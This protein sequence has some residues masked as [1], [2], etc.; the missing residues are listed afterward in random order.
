MRLVLFIC[1]LISAA[2]SALAQESQPITKRGRGISEVPQVQE[3]LIVS[4][5]TSGLGDVS[6]MI[7]DVDGSIYTSDQT[8]GRVFKVIDRNKDGVLDQSRVIADGFSSPSGLAVIGNYLYVADAKAIWTVPLNGGPKTAFVSLG[9]SKS[10]GGSRPL[11]AVLPKRSDASG[12]LVI[13]LNKQDG[14]GQLVSI[15]LSTRRA[16]LLAE[17]PDAILSFARSGQSLWVGTANAI[18]PVRDGA[19]LLS[20]AFS[21]KAPVT[22][23]ILPGQF[24][25]NPEEFDR[26]AEH[27][28]VSLGHTDRQGTMTKGSMVKTIPTKFGNTSGLP[29]PFVTGFTASGNRT[30]WGKPGAMWMDERGLFLAD[31]WSGTVWRISADVP[32]AVIKDPQVIPAAIEAPEAKTPTSTVLPLIDGIEQTPAATLKKGSQIESA[33]SLKV[34]STIVQK[35]E[36]DKKAKADAK[37]KAKA[38]KSKE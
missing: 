32:K 5:F 31:S 15:D 36:A 13:G 29:Q 33:S 7:G 1:L 9:N 22:G 3:G 35:W 14:R 27:M 6:A 18:A 34:G 17:G 26:W 24:T 4:R 16:D 20:E 19:I 2:T 30:A 23:L 38:A 12:A 21:L 25:K 8:R 11:I 28:I 10:A 37:K